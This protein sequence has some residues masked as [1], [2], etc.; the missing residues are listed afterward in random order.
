MFMA[1]LVISFG[2]S[3]KCAVWKRNP[4]FTRK[5]FKFSCFKLVA[6]ALIGMYCGHLCQQAEE[7]IMHHKKTD[8]ASFAIPEETP[9]FSAR[10]NLKA[11]HHHKHHK[12]HANPGAFFAVLIAGFFGTHLYFLKSLEQHQ[13]KEQEANTIVPSDVYYPEQIPQVMPVP[14]DQESFG[15][16]IPFNYP[17]QS[18]FDPKWCND[19]MNTKTIHQVGCLMSSTSMAINGCGITI[20]GAASTPQTLNNWLKAHGGYD[21]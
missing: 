10:R 11:K 9:V 14:R 4:E 5:V 15:M 2:K 17:L 7:I 8:D 12:K 6:I 13:R 21:G 16:T 20:N 19:L 18:Q 3:A 1:A